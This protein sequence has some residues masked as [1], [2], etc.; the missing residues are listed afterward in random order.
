MTRKIELFELAGQNSDYLRQQYQSLKKNGRK[1]KVALMEDFC[2]RLRDTWDI[3]A[4]LSDWA[5][6]DWLDSGTFKNIYEVKELQASQLVENEVIT[7]S[8]KDDAL[9][10]ALKAHLG[11][12]FQQR[13]RFDST[14]RKGK[15]L[16]Y[17]A[18]NIGGPGIHRYGD[19]CAVVDR[20][21]VRKYKTLAFIKLDSAI[22]YMEKGK[23]QLKKLE[24]DL[25]VEV[26]MPLLGVVKHESSLQL[27]PPDQWDGMICSENDYIEAVTCDSIICDHIKTVRVKK[28]FYNTIFKDL[29]LK[30][31]KKEPLGKDELYRLN[32]FKHILM[33][34][35]KRDIGLEIMDEN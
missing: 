14:F 3:S 31:F 7:P 11:G 30:Q 9:H 6:V 2:T 32:F 16:K 26:C 20:E 35:K 23:I 10:G 33:E 25:A 21:K 29:L 1:K 15:Q 17:L 19:F 22:N 13:T 27:C 34:I 8:E 4:N 28:S 5:L 24:Q 12:F 18:L